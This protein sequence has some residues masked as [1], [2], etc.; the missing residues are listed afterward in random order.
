[1]SE[2]TTTK[3]RGFGYAAVIAAGLLGLV[4]GG[5]VSTAVGH[6]MVG[7]GFRHFGGHHDRGPVDPAEAKEHA[8]RMAGH[9]AWAVDATDAQ[10]QQLTQI[11][12]AM[13]NDLLPAHE[14][15]RSARGKI[16]NLLRAPKTDRAA[17]EAMRKAAR[18]CINTG[19]S[20]YDDNYPLELRELSDA[21]TIAD[22]VLA[23]ARGEL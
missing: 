7:A 11:A 20:P 6:N 14:K 9:L 10:K 19:P 15:M 8:A 18:N 12:Q 13:V 1:M 4:G 16:A 17:L 21:W 5:L 3:R 23:K 22:T 2:Q